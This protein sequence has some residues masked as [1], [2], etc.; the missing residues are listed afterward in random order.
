VQQEL[1]KA[2][3]FGTQPPTT[4]EMRH[5]KNELLSL[6]VCFPIRLHS[7]ALTST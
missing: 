4:T 1:N 3:T 7:S 2:C 6:F 5:R